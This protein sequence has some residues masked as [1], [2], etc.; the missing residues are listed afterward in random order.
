MTR[1]YDVLDMVQQSDCIYTDG[2]LRIDSPVAF[3][4]LIHLTYKQTIRL[5]DWLTWVIVHWK[6]ED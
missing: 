1:N 3:G 5:R 2:E 4:A 6:A